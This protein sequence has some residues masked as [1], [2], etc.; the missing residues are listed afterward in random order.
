MIPAQ[1]LLTLDQVPGMG[2]RKVRNLINTYPNISDWPDLLDRNL[3]QVEGLSDV[4]VK[5]IRS[6]RAARSNQASAGRPSVS[7]LV[8]TP[9]AANAAAASGHSCCAA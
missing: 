9:R 6:A 2:H 3:Q 7:V 8:P 4:L 1:V 5:R